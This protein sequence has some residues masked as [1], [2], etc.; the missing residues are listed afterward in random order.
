[1][2][3]RRSTQWAGAP[4]ERN[5]GSKF[6][7]NDLVARLVAGALAYAE[8]YST[9]SASPAAM[10]SAPGPG[11]DHEAIGDEQAWAMPKRLRTR[12]TTGNSMVTS[13]VLPG[14]G[15]DAIGRSAS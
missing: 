4:L 1:M 13:A 5:S 6:S 8:E 3:R 11:A 2:R 14:I 7:R 10:V 15:N 9:F 12:F